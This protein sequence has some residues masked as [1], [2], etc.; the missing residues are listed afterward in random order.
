MPKRGGAG[1]MRFLQAAKELNLPRIVSIQNNYSLLVRLHYDI[2]LGEVCHPKNGNV[3]LLAYSPLAGGALSGKYVDGTASQ[4]SR[5][6]LFEGTA[7]LHLRWR[8]HVTVYVP[9]VSW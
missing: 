2:D 5:F 7:I 8:L 1:V 9:H 4:G 3:A 6:N